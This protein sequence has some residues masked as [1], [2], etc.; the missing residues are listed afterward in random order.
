MVWA[1]TAAT[2]NDAD[3]IAD[4]HMAAF[5]SNELL[6]AQFPDPDVRTQLRDCI[7]RKAADDIRDPNI[8]VLVTRDQDKIV[9]F[10]KWSLPVAASESHVEAPWALPSSEPTLNTNAAGQPRL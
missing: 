8:A 5:G 4:I 6:L 2:A 7:A 3:R 9:S 1:V 10:A